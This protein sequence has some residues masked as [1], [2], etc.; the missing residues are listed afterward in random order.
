MLI[1]LLNQIN[2][3]PQQIASRTMSK[4]MGVEVPITLYAFFEGEKISNEYSEFVK[5]IQVL[6]GK[7]AVQIKG[8]QPAQIQAGELFV[9][10]AK[11]SH[12]ITALLNTKFL[13]IEL[14]PKH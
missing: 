8:E 3:H 6:E 9:V 7:L 1:N 10:P 11:Q 4:K 12:Q 5:L 13:Q 14:S 2:Y